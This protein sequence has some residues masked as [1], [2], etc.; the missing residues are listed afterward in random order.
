MPATQTYP[1][2][3]PTG[4]PASTADCQPFGGCVPH[5]HPLLASGARPVMVSSCE[6]SRTC[7]L[8]C[9]RGTALT[10]SWTDRWRLP[11][12]PTVVTT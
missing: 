4:P 3:R 10:S 8:A 5:R 2:N 6:P 7:D 12:Q 1:A 11:D 9:G